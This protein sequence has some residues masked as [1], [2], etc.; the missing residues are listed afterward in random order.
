MNARVIPIR[1]PSDPLPHDPSLGMALSAMWENHTERVILGAAMLGERVP[2]WLEPRHFFPTQ[3]QRIFEAVR[4]VGGNVAHV[5]RWMSLASPK[6]KP[7][8]VKSTELA[9]M[10]YEGD[11]HV[12]QGW[13][14]VDECEGVRELWKRRQL[15]EA[16]HRAVVELRGGGSHAAAYEAMKLH[17]KDMKR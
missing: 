8:L 9:A 4:E 13:A 10:C 5:F 14:L 7:L 16:C 11:W 3:H 17:F 15:V 2:D 1:A 12:R 6:Y